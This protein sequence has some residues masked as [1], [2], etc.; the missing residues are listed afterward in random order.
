MRREVSNIQ[1]AHPPSVRREMF[2]ERNAHQHLVAPLG[3]R[4]LAPS[5]AKNIDGTL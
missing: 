5:G 2:I 3:A 1:L 4:C